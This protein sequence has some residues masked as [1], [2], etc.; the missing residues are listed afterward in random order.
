M[1]ILWNNLQK[2]PYAIPEFLLDLMIYPSQTK[3]TV[4]G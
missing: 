4:L 1:I 2:Q 3:S